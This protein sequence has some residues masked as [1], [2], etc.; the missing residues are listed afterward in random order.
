MRHSGMKQEGVKEG[1][2]ERGRREGEGGKE[3]STSF[4]T[5]HTHLTR[6]AHRLIHDRGIAVFQIK[7]HG[8]LQRD[9]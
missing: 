4:H 2:G 8:G 3:R 9:Q 5:T 1:G 7:V 6:L